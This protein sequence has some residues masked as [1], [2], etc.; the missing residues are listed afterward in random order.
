MV[1]NLNICIVIFHCGIYRVFLDIS[2]QR[3]EIIKI[4]NKLSIHR[5]E[6]KILI[7]DIPRNYMYFDILTH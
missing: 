6:K 3:I 7:N 2:M 5:I 4:E 1:K